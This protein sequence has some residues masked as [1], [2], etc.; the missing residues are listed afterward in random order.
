MPVPEMSASSRNP[1]R[2]A[3]EIIP[4]RF[5][6]CA[7]KE[8]LQNHKILIRNPFFNS[9]NPDQKFPVVCLNVD[10][11]LV[12]WNFFL[13]FGPLN[14]GQ[15]HRFTT[16]LNKLLANAR[17]DGN[18]NTTVLF[19]SST[20][21]NKRAN[22]I[23]LACAWQVLELNRTPEEAFRGFSMAG[24]K[25][26]NNHCNSNANANAS[27]HTQQNT[28]QQRSMTSSNPPLLP[29]SGIGR[30]TIAGLPPFHD[31]SP[32][33]CS[34]ELTLMDCLGALVKARQF[35]F[36]DWGEK[37]DVKEYEYFEQVE[38]GDLNWIV[39]GKILAFAG[40]SYKKNVS[41]EGYCTLAPGDYI[42]YFQRKQI[43]LVVRLNQK[44]Y[45]EQQFIDAGIDHVE[46]FY[47]DGSCP[48]MSILQ[49][50]VASFEK[51]PH[52]KGFAVHCKAGLG[53][54]GTCVG[55]YIMKHYRMTAKEVIGWM[56][57]CRPGMVIGPQQQFLEKIQGLMW[58]EGD[59]MRRRAEESQS[60]SMLAPMQTQQ[61]YYPSKEN[62]SSPS[63]RSVLTTATAPETPNSVV[64][65]TASSK[66]IGHEVIL[67][68]I[69]T[70]QYRYEC[71]N[72]VEDQSTYER[73]KINGR[74]GQADG[75][76]AARH[77]NRGQQ[78]QQSPMANDT[79]DAEHNKNN[80]PAVPVTPDNRGTSSSSMWAR[81][82][83]DGQEFNKGKSIATTTTST[84]TFE[85]LG[86][87]GLVKE[88]IF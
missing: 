82:F 3:V 30:Q 8:R 63:S 76:L 28:K 19:Y 44:N 65:A 72:N 59:A 37:F 41:P 70:H 55:A 58:Q 48:H 6:Y 14:L 38:N 56:R 17:R 42:P 46:E 84:T 11:E 80:S 71:S 36:F 24:Y 20:V 79:T 62:P 61:E 67:N 31:A 86:W 64:L 77:N 25:P 4:N 88:Q 34:Y 68:G 7:L 51:V 50:V 40:P 1:L 57:I 32:Y 33:R 81:A 18:A 83:G 35:N 10:E 47:T 53:R 66:E 45:D 2:G 75:L 52:H 69:G 23:F 15:L 73:E 21:H 27:F 74:P 43:G 12:Y 60:T 87:N 22:A 54:T 16:R 5:Y 49:R 78:Q 39:K 13:D 29:L 26:L 85:C 9:T